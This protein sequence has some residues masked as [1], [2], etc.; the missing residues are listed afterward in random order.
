MTLCIIKAFPD[1]WHI[2]TFKSLIVLIK[3]L[4]TESDIKSILDMVIMRFTYFANNGNNIKNMDINIFS[5]LYS[6][7]N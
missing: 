2:A 3:G 1:E 5:E 6:L 4:N 7:L